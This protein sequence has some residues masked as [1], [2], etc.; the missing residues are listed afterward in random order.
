MGEDALRFRERASVCRQ[1][2]KE[3][4][5]EEAR[6]TLS[7]MGDELDAEADRLEAEEA[8]SKIIIERRAEG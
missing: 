4:R 1:L 6:R 3:A 8:A 5:D 2:A 7:E